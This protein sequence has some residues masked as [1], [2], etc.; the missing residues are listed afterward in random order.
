MNVSSL[1]ARSF[2]FTT[3]LYPCFPCGH[4]SL[5]LLIP[6]NCALFCVYCSVLVINL[7]PLAPRLRCWICFIFLC[8]RP[9]RFV[10]R[11]DRSCYD[12]WFCS[13][14]HGWHRESAFCLRARTQLETQPQVQRRGIWIVLCLI[15]Q[16]DHRVVLV[17]KMYKSKWSLSITISTPPLSLHASNFA[18]QNIRTGP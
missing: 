11:C 8:M 16:S 13:H 17:M 12:E 7:R 18:V 2:S 14:L 9:V 3:P 15:E 5:Y 10:T 4:I 1:N 6:C